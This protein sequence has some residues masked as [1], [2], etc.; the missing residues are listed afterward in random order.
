MFEKKLEEAILQVQS[1]NTGH[2]NKQKEYTDANY[3]WDTR[4]QEW[5]DYLISN[6]K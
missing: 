2:L 3:S 4:I 5:N 6:A 1:G